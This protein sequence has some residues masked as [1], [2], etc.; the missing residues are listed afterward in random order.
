[1]ISGLNLSRQA[2]HRTWAE[3]IT[4]LKEQL[5][6]LDLSNSTRWTDVDWVTKC[7]TKLTKLV[8]SIHT[9][10]ILLFVVLI[11]LPFCSEV[12]KKFYEFNAPDFL[13]VIMQS[14]SFTDNIS[15]KKRFNKV[16]TDKLR[17]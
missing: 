8:K 1:M 7:I 6:F 3:S 15:V 13:I 10:S 14:C 17:T 4:L 5:T 16:I 9:S 12:K 2:L 11:K